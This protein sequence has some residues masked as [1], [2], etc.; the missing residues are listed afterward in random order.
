MPA[1]PL[2]SFGDSI[3]DESDDNSNDMLSSARGMTAH[4][5]LTLCMFMF[6]VFVLNPF[7]QL[8][9]GGSINVEN[10]EGDYTGR[11]VL[12]EKDG[13]MLSFLINY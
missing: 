3:K 12:Q 7:S 13:G 11:K 9:N 1:S 5:R 4:S 6:A 10:F 2:T 8:L